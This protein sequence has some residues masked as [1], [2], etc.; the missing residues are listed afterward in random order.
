M[1]DLFPYSTK[2]L[3]EMFA[4]RKGD[5]S[6]LIISEGVP[7][8]S[9]TREEF[10]GYL[11]SLGSAF[12]LN[13]LTAEQCLANVD[14]TKMV[15]DCGEAV[16]SLT[17]HSSNIPPSSFLFNNVWVEKANTFLNVNDDHF[18]LLVSER[19]ES[20]IY[21]GH[22]KAVERLAI[23]FEGDIKLIRVNN[24]IRRNN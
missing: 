7:V 1:K 5:I 4:L 16:I 18:L 3:E 19:V 24:F 2:S 10:I 20:P 23:N 9:P 12:R 6:E 14:V 13:V 15:I 17:T 21:L 11:P 22:E 8:Y